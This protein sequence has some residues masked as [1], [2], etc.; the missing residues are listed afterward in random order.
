MR[1]FLIALA[2]GVGAATAVAQP[3][4]GD[5]ARFEQMCTRVS[6]ADGLPAEAVA[7]FCSCLAE[8]ATQSASLYT[9][10][11]NAAQSEPNAERRME[12]LSQAGREAVQACRAP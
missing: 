6:T 12:I 3:Q 4:T 10:L 7:S 9:E 8:R 1:V 11:S 2:V 5:R